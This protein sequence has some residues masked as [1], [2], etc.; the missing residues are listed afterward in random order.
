MLLNCHCKRINERR[1]KVVDRMEI[2]KAKAVGVYADELLARPGFS[3]HV[4][5]VVSNAVYLQSVDGEI[6]WLAREDLAAHRRAIL[7]H[8]DYTGV[9]IG[10]PCGMRATKL[11]IG[12]E[13]QVEL[14]GASVWQPAAIPSARVVR[15]GIVNALVRQLLDTAR[16]YE[17]GESLGQMLP[18]ITAAIGEDPV[19][20]TYEN[21]TLRAAFP[22]VKQ[23]VR[24]CHSRDLTHIAQAGRALVGL[25]PG[26]TP[27]G[28]DFLGGLFFVAFHLRAAYPNELDWEQRPIDDLLVWARE[29]TNAISHAIL[30]DHARGDGAEPLHTLIASLLQGHD[31]PLRAV[32]S[33]L[34]I[35]STSGWDIFAGAMVGMQ[36]LADLDD[37]E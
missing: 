7:G 22:V 34:E 35:G 37:R 3:G 5:A 24:A 23:I 6:I 12:E 10:L 32:R 2:G 15:P 8:F 27:S 31:L 21:L 20:T 1:K 14:A 36:L 9:R 11:Y 33:L 25:G 18:L 4:L 16:S 30:H 19:R 26:L 29:Q 17:C 13:Q 28:D